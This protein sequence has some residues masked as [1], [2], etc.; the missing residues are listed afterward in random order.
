MK[1]RVLAAFRLSVL[2]A[3]AG[4]AAPR[5]TKPPSPPPVPPPGPIAIPGRPVRPPMAAVPPAA[6]SLVRSAKAYIGMREPKDAPT[7]GPDFVRRVFAQNGIPLPRKTEE[8]SLLGQRVASAEELRSGDVVFL[9]ESPSSRMIDRV[10][11]YLSDGVF[12]HF[13]NPSV[14]VVEES[15]DTEFYRRRYL[16]ARR[17]IP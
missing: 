10:G 16:T 15:L 5:Q 13:V 11:I 4:C 3:A 14:G 17:I 7:D 9:S 1:R 6:Q 12:I 8:L 2:A